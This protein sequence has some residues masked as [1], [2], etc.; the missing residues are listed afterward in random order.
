MHQSCS[1]QLCIDSGSQGSVLI[2]DEASPTAVTVTCAS[3]TPPMSVNSS[4]DTTNLLSIVP[5]FEHSTVLIYECVC[6]LCKVRTPL[7]RRSL[8][9]PAVGGTQRQREVDPETHN[10][11]RLHHT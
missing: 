5:A 1:S 8:V 3:A 7:S 11:L 6:G 2:L 10:S 4:T 9:K